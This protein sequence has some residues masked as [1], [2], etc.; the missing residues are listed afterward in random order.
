VIV[1]Q[2]QSPEVSKAVG[3]GV[4][5]ILFMPVLFWE[6]RHHKWF[7]PYMLL[8]V[9]AHLIVI[10]LLPWARMPEPISGR[11][12][13]FLLLGIIDMLIC[14]FLGFLSASLT[15]RCSALSL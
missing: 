6:K 7:F 8:I 13:I 15:R 5:A 4:A 9:A 10:P 12:D 14:A 1:G 11:K 2:W 3:N